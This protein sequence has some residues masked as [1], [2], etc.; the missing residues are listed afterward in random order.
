MALRALHGS[1]RK[2]L[3]LLFLLSALPAL[4]LILLA[5]VQNRNK[6]LEEARQDLLSFVRRAAES[7]ERSTEATRKMMENLSR[8][9]DIRSG[10]LAACTR[11]FTNVLRINQQR[12]ATLYLVDLDG[13]MLATGNPN[14]DPEVARTKHFR[15]AVA[16]RAFA[17]GEYQ[18]GPRRGEA[19][20]SFGCPVFDEAG[21]VSGV[22]IAS[23]LLSGYGDQFKDMHLP[24]DSYLGLCDHQGLRLGRVPA[25]P[26]A[27]AGQAINA[28]VF[29]AARSGGEEG[30]TDYADAKGMERLMAFRKLR[31][32]P[33]KTP[34]MYV[35]V[36]E[37][38]ARI[39]ARAWESLTRDLG[40][41]ALMV[42]LTLV[43]GWYLGGRN[44][45]R[46]LEELAAAATRVGEGDLSVRVDAELGVDEIDILAGS[47]NS[48]A[49][50]L[51]R[52][53]AERLRNE[54]ELRL[55]KGQAE[56]A[57]RAK[58]QFLA[59][60]SHEL[61]TPLN[62]LLGML[63]L[64]KGGGEPGEVDAFVDAAYRSGQRL[65]NLL[66]DL[67]DLS[68]IEAGRM[69]IEVRPFALAS[70]FSALSE[71]F[72]PMNH[73]KRV[74]LVIE[75]DPRV[76][77]QIVGDEIR[78]RQILFNLVGNAMKFTDQGEVR[79]EV[80]PLLPLPSGKAR[81]LFL[82]SD[83]GI[84]IPDEMIGQICSPFTQVSEDYTRSHQGAGLGLSIVHSLVAAMG[85]TLEID[86]LVGQGTRVCVVLPFPLP[87]PAGTVAATGREREPAPQGRLRLLLAEDDEVSR[88]SGRLLLERM[89]HEVTTVANGAEALDALRAAH[90]DCVLMDVQMPVMSGLEATRRVRGGESGV[91]NPRIP[92]IAMTA[93][94]MTGD[95]EQFLAAG[96]DDYVAKPVTSEELAK[97]IARTVEQ[98]G[99][100]TGR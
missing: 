85:G 72:S 93:Y 31:L 96:M 37:P 80:W 8:V 97:V 10:D 9:P 36:A 81:L 22:I 94:A 88:L 19:T 48:M 58:S 62:G 50:T 26:E 13:R 75:C 86:S 74:P 46:R 20:L 25:T 44:M 17:V 30:L 49:E 67:L 61:R 52:D 60:M 87:G 71:T 63:Q 98:E 1:I 35:F 92:V 90:F 28:S 15:D 95:R 69:R 4:I 7:Q 3:A 39:N 66:G 43:S 57:N 53:R 27:P 70:V 84:G 29:E 54:A 45:G 82:V 34:Y 6:A 59:N 23:V 65:T 79:L 64:I 11:I 51:E 83:T 18:P 42:V 2:K 21:S 40:V 33:G 14:V 56:A 78:V 16:A 12:Y 32:D 77:P 47:F 73:S 89:G 41:L 5:G 55:A 100:A 76:P 91:L 24:E 38:K 68:R 99:A